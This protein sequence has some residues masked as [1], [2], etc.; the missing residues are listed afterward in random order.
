MR[1]FIKNIRDKINDVLDDIAANLGLHPKA[2]PAR[3]KNN[4]DRKKKR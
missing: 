2:V 3:A 4:K 1:K